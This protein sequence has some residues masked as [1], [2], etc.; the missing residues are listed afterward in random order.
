MFDGITRSPVIKTRDNEIQFFSRAGQKRLRDLYNNSAE[1]L[2]LPPHS[3]LLYPVL[4]RS[5]P[6]CPDLLLS[7]LPYSSPLF[8]TLLRSSVL[9][10]TT[11][12]S[13][14]TK[15]KLH[16]IYVLAMLLNS[17]CA[18]LLCRPAN[19]FLKHD[20][21]EREREK[22][23]RNIRPSASHVAFSET[24]NANCFRWIMPIQQMRLFHV[25]VFS[26]MLVPSLTYP[27]WGKGGKVG[28]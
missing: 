28:Q 24:N 5:V 2:L 7:T 21:E 18:T 27:K 17:W 6:F 11:L 14:G 1:R 15:A 25:T 12:R 16:V 19:H 22:K 8:C 4:S 26:W 3:V 20:K 9:V 23:K 10:S 13:G